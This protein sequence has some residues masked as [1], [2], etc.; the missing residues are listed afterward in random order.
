MLMQLAVSAALAVTPMQNTDTTFAVDPSL[1]LDVSTY[2]GDISVRTWDRNEVRLRAEHSR[3]DRMV[4]ERTET[5]VRIRPA[6]WA[7]W[8]EDFEVAFERDEVRVHQESPRMPSIVDLELTVP[9]TMAL[10]LGGPFTDVTVEGSRAE[11][12]IQVKE[13]DVV[14]RGGAGR[15]NVR[16]VEGDVTIEGATATVRAITLDGDVTLENVTGDVTVETTD[17]EIQLDDVRATNIE[18]YTVDGD[19]W[20][21]GPIAAQGLYSFLTHDGDITLHLPRDVSARVM[22][23]TLDGEFT[24]DFRVSL[25]ERHAGRR[26]NFTLGGGGG[27]IEIE[28]FDGDV[29]LLQREP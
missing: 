16:A 2:A 28:T 13:G 19:I 8:A 23:A 7:R 6:S 11:I 21:A 20:F 12:A 15:V 3:R 4:V 5:E 1:R 22:L 29:D 25:P 24:T 9:A 27:Q 17:G 10:D 14:V 26:V 18:A